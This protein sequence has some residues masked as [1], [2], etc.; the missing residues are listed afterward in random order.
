MARLKSRADSCQTFREA[1]GK[2]G[3]MLRLE[4]LAKRSPVAVTRRVFD[5]A[6]ASV[7]RY[8]DHGLKGSRVRSRR[9]MWTA[10]Q[11]QASQLSTRFRASS[12]RQR[13][14]ALKCLIHHYNDTIIN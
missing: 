2:S 1:L 6:V 14:V 10:T 3:L 9:R 7:S 12:L 4:P 11:R 8:T 13:A 5:V